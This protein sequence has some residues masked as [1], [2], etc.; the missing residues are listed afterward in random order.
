MKTLPIQADDGVL[1]LDMSSLKPI[2]YDRGAAALFIDRSSAR[3]EPQ[4]ECSI[5]DEIVKAIQTAKPSDL[6]TLKTPFHVGR[7]RYVCR[8]YPMEFPIDGSPKIV[9]LHL[10]R[11][12]HSS[13]GVDEL[14]A[15]YDLTQREQ[16][17]LLGISRGLTCK[18]IAVLMNISPNTVKAY[19]RLI[20][21]KMGVTRRAGIMG[22]LLEHTV[23]GMNGGCD[24]DEEVSL[25]PANGTLR[26]VSNG[27]RVGSRTPAMAGRR[28]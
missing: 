22:K 4:S 11:S 1:L 16:E 8:T 10:H 25:T 28:G 7:E 12:P 27:T 26:A 23:N 2:A 17:A 9:A 3:Q 14:A 15:Q 19:L 21:V 20:M 18:E 24:Y 6:P 13:Y 5:P